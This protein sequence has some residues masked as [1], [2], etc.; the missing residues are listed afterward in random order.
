MAEVCPEVLHLEF[1][2]PKLDNITFFQ[3]VV[4]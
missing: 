3:S 4:L 2:T 1:D